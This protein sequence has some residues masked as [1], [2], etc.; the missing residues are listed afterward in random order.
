M[1]HYDVYTF[2]DRFLIVVKNQEYKGAH[3]LISDNVTVNFLSIAGHLE[4]LV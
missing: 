4:S 1:L 3:L 2:C